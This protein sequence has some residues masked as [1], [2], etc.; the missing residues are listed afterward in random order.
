MIFNSAKLTV[1]SFVREEWKRIVREFDGKIPHEQLEKIFSEIDKL[2]DEK[3][4]DM[5][6]SPADMKAAAGIPATG[7]M[8]Q[9]K[10][11]KTLGSDKKISAATGNKA[12]TKEK[13]P[14]ANKKAK[15]G[16]SAKRS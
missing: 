15:G 11:Q 1:P 8:I 3:I 13:A 16:R 6:M 12:A 10:A 14:D 9:G 4:K 5:F 7:N 2:S